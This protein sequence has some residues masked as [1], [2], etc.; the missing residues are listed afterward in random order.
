[1]SLDNVNNSN[2]H[3]KK[4]ETVDTTTQ[5]KEYK[6]ILDKTINSILNGEKT[7]SVDKLKENSLFLNLS[8]KGL[9]RFNY[10]AGID[11]DTKSFNVEEL[12][13][14]FSLSDA[15]LKNN[16]FVFDAKYDTDMDS[17][18]EQAYDSE[19]ENM[20]KNLVT[21]NVRKRIKSTD[22]TKFDR[23]KD[24]V[25]KVAS[26]DVD[27]SML[28]MQDKL[29]SGFVD[30]RTGNPVSI[31]KAIV[32]FYDFMEQN[33]GLLYDESQKQFEELTGIKISDFQRLR[34]MGDG[35]SFILGDWK[36]NR[37]EITNT[38]TGEKLE[39]LTSSWR[40]SK[41]HTVPA[42]KGNICLIKSYQDGKGTTVKYNYDDS[43]NI[44][45]TSADITIN[46]EFKKVNYE[47]KFSVDP[48]LYNFI[49]NLKPQKVF[50][51]ASTT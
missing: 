38:V 15:S 18:L 22:I 4:W 20:I 49:D 1:M 7:I 11:G 16:K 51:K 29:Q 27:E 17:G 21:S 25:E 8:E 36:Y 34:C 39:V 50:K 37:G 6:N 41:P 47:K 3:I 35:D 43:E 30:K 28:A 40:D 48:E 46:G 19:V 9:E 45:P 31:T 5:D 32:M 2:A 12:R 44:A 23:S 13:V 42:A 33:R 26:N 10:I 24:F 14:L